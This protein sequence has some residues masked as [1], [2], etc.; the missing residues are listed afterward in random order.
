MTNPPSASSCRRRSATSCALGRS[1]NVPLRDRGGRPCPMCSRRGRYPLRSD[2]AE[3]PRPVASRAWQAPA[4]RVAGR[5]ACAT[6]ASTAGAWVA[7]AVSAGE[8]ADGSTF[9]R[10]RCWRLHHRNRETDGGPMSSRKEDDGE[11]QSDG[12]QEMAS[13][14]RPRSSRRPRRRHG[15]VHRRTLMRRTVALRCSC[16]FRGLAAEWRACGR[17]DSRIARAGMASAWHRHARSAPVQ[18]RL[19]PPAASRWPR[20][21]SG[22]LRDQRKPASAQ[23][24]RSRRSSTGRNRA[25][26][27]VAG[28][29]HCLRITRSP[30]SH[31]A[32]RRGIRCRSGIGSAAARIQVRLAS[33]PG[34]AA[35]FGERRRPR[36]GNSRETPRRPARAT[37]PA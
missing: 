19:R 27:Q 25:G 14:F 7:F 3:S 9:T 24:C 29:R 26:P 34:P 6:R 18:G 20:R 11:A 5:R 21:L 22:P 13:S 2:D 4:R 15:D 32:A 16:R 36:Q 17:V 33:T 30:A 12:G 23:P 1:S 8:G 31:R 35:R 37:A 10:I 28:D